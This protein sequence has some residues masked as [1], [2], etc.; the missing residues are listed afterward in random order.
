[1]PLGEATSNRRRI[2]QAAA[3]RDRLAGRERQLG[4]VRQSQFVVT[5]NLNRR[6]L[7][8][9]RE[10]KSVSDRAAENATKNL[11]SHKTP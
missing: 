6:S 4:I 2:N 5:R 9:V 1:M 8:F 3:T 11:V 10:A 7:P